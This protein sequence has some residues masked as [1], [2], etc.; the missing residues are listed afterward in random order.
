[1]C[2]E[3]KCFDEDEHDN[4]WDADVAMAL[5]KGTNRKTRRVANVANFRLRKN[6]EKGSIA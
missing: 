3:L 2:S 6:N 1:M 4:D 5:C